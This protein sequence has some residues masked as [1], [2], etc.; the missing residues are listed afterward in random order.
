MSRPALRRRKLST[1]T[2]TLS[3]FTLLLAVVAVLPPDT[4]LQLVK[5]S[6]VLRVCVPDRYPPLVT[7]DPAAPGVDLDIVS[8]ISAELGVR[9]VVNTNSAMGRDWNPRNWRVTRGQC[10]VIAGGV[11]DSMTTRIFLDT[12]RPYFET[13]W[14]LVM[15]VEVSTLDGAAVGFHPGVSGLDRIA[16]SRFLRAQGARTTPV[17]TVEELEAGLRSGRFTV[18]ISEALNVRVLA[19]RNGWIAQWLPEE[20]GRHGI[21]L[22]LW[23][24]DVTLKRAVARALEAKRRDGTLAR[25][26]E[27]YRLTEIGEECTPCRLPGSGP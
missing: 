11:V 5:G 24:G 10:Q 27:R 22:G 12:I 20:L 14:A 17:S 18:G 19:G 7:G 2:I 26:V 1:G 23:K 21:T 25:I 9:L 16:L 15:P 8:A 3:V 6:G 13:G 4:S